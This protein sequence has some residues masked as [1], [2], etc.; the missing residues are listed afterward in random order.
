MR[1]GLLVSGVLCLVGLLGANRW[2]MNVRNFGIIGYALVLPV[3]LLLMGR[4]FAGSPAA[5]DDHRISRAQQ[6]A[7]RLAAG[8]DWQENGL[9]Y[10]TRTGTEMDAA[11]IRRDLRR[12]L[13]N[14]PG[15]VAAEWTPRELRHS[16]VSVLSDRHTR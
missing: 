7:D 10:T 8:E 5:D 2:N 15:L 14:V 1:R 11:N 6:A 12:A 3:V 4:L 13:R 9:V 16:F